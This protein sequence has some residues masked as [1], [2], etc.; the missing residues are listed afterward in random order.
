MPNIGSK[1]VLP[2]FLFSFQF[3]PVQTLANEPC[4]YQGNYVFPEFANAGK[5]TTLEIGLQPPEEQIGRIN[6]LL[7]R[8]NWELLSEEE[9]SVT[10]KRLRIRKGV[11]R[12][13]VT[14]FIE[15]VPNTFLPLIDHVFTNTGI[16]STLSTENDG[17]DPLTIIPLDQ[18][19]V[20]AIEQVNVV[21]GSNRFGNGEPGSATGTLFLDASIN[22]CTGRSEFEF[23]PEHNGNE[24]HICFGQEY[25]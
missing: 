12:G 19:T 1:L 7:I 25:C 23:I 13:K 22:A 20:W 3:I 15:P 5:V 2:I 14:D 11:I 8:E 9:Q 16:N 18:C 24:T 10:C 6:L 4:L 17:L 21:K